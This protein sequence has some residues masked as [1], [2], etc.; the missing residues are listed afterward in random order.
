[1][2]RMRALVTGAGGF[3]GSHLTELLVRAGWDVT[4]FVRYSSHDQLGALVHAEPDVLANVDVVAG[5]LRDDGSVRA[6]MRGCEAVLHLGAVISIPYSYRAPREVVETNVVG[7]LNVLSAARDLDLRRV[8]HTSTSEVYGSAQSERI[9]EA[10]VLQGQS[11][12]SAS[13]IGADKLAEAFHR[14]FGTPVVTLRPFNT[15]GPR[16]SPRAVIPTIL[17]AALAGNPV[18]LGSLTPTRDFTFVTDTAEAFLRAA[19]AQ[20]IDG[21]TIHLGVGTETS[22]AEVVRLAGELVGHELEVVV[23]DERIRPPDSEVARLRSDPRRARDQLGWVPQ[24]SLAEGLKRT[25][26][27]LAA[28]G[29]EWFRLPGYA[30]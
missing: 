22:I 12:Y 29:A 26:D 3:I 20:G 10:H 16:Q 17:T 24:V 11:P 4:A 28:G 27:W 5:D 7:T 8:V 9:D 2:P 23:E 30:T 13:K 6:A 1:M 14:S 15:Y 21:E 25:A 19:G 18:K